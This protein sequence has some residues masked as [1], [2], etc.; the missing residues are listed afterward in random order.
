MA[1]LH[2]TVEGAGTGKAAGLEHEA[3]PIRD[4]LLGD[5]W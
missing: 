3:W 5:D 1:D 4:Q 2:C